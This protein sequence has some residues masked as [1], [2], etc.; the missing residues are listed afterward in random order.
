MEDKNLKEKEDMKTI[1]EL[2]EM[3]PEPTWIGYREA[4]K[5]VLKLIDDMKAD[6]LQS[7]KEVLKELKQKI[8]GA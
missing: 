5:D 6:D 4:L 1:K 2:D 8:Q 3:S 7:A